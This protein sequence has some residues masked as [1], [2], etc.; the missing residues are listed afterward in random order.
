MGSAFGDD[1]EEEEVQAKPAKRVRNAFIQDEVDVEDEEDEED[2]EEEGLDN[3][4]YEE[5]ANAENISGVQA[6]RQNRSLDAQRRKE[7][8]AKLREQVAA[9]YEGEGASRFTHAEDIEDDDT[10]FKDL[11][12][13][14]RDPKLW[15]I[16][17]KPN[18]EKMLVISLMQKYLDSMHTEKP[19]QIKSAMC[20]DVKGYIYLEAFKEL[21]VRE[22]TQGLNN[23]FFRITQ[24]PN[25]EMTDVM[26]VRVAAKRKPLVRGAWCRMKRN[27]EYKD[28]LAQVTDIDVDGSRATVR[29]I[30]RLRI[31]LTRGND[32][33]DQPSSRVRPPAKLF[34]PEEIESFNGTVNYTVDGGK[35]TYHFDGQQFQDGARRAT[36]ESAPKC[37]PPNAM[38]ATRRAGSAPAAPAPRCSA[39]P[40]SPPS[41]HLRHH[42]ATSPTLPP[43]HVPHSPPAHLPPL[44]PRS[45]QACS[46]RIS[47]RA[48]SAGTIRSRPPS[49]SSSASRRASALARRPSCSGRSRQGSWRPRTPSDPATSSRYA[50]ACT[51]REP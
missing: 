28:D 22:A 14:A 9:R 21:H 48:G 10:R 16:K 20:T 5:D 37:A 15:I 33:E 23:L 42:L 17:C 44:P 39:P 32:D 45:P 49:P 8:D 41:T 6:E 35:R 25:N 11:P 29:L 3:D 24:V 40:H 43:P 30:P 2:D 7:E 12:D 34:K 38:R 1:D 27:D 4:E 31:H 13:A 19:L 26:R 46:S 36:R 18:A 50:R 47:P 51:R